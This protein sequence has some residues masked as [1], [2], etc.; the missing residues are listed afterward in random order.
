MNRRDPAWRWCCL[1]LGVLNLDGRLRELDGGFRLDQARPG[2][3]NH[4]LGF[5]ASASSSGA[6]IWA[7][8]WPFFT[9]SPMSTVRVFR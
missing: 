3:L 2:L 8:S 7:R 5:F 9:A 6:S 4:G 1:D